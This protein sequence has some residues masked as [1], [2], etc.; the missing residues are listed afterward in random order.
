[1]EAGGRGL[2]GV[3]MAAAVVAWEVGAREQVASTEP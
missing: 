1:L 3:L 2:G